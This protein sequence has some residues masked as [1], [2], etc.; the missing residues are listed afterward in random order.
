MKVR[1]FID[2]FAE[3]VQ[4]LFE[5][6]ITAAARAGH[7]NRPQLSKILRGDAPP[8]A[9]SRLEDILARWRVP[10]DRAEEVLQ[11]AR[12][13]KMNPP[14]RQFVSKLGILEQPG[15][16]GKGTIMP[17]GP[18]RKPL[19]LMIS[20]KDAEKDLY[21]E[22]VPLEGSFSQTGGFLGL[23]DDVEEGEREYVVYGPV[24]TG[25]IAV[26]IDDDLEGLPGGFR[27]F[28]IFG[29]EARVQG[30]GLGLFELRGDPAV[31]VAS[32]E[33]ADGGVLL[34]YRH[35]KN[36]VPFSTVKSFRPFVAAV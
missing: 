20:E 5:G 16:Q 17:P 34:V 23:E 3:V 32:Y 30:S 15:L 13:R 27:G 4:D 11:A 35:R 9:L 18:R 10:A 33:K 31:V 28:A 29:P 2:V 8:P 25:S 24:P 22:Y 19:I 26:R 21:V 6:N 12:Y 1:E 36:R 7:Y 14:G